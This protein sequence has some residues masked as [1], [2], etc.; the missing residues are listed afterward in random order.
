MYNKC[1]K[2]GK[3]ITYKVS[4]RRFCL[5]CGIK[6]YHIIVFLKRFDAILKH[7]RSVFEVL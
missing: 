6:H 1:L 7:I 5:M 4:H 2:C 3:Y